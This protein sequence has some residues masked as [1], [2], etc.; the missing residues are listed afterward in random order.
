MADKKILAAQEE[1]CGSHNS[2][3]EEVSEWVTERVLREDR[4]QSTGLTMSEP[5]NMVPND[6]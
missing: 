2:S 4:N 3:Y 1:L 6:P 5:Q